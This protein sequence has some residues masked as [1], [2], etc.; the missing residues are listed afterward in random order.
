MEHHI[1]FGSNIT[2]TTS[3]CVPKCATGAFPL[4]GYTLWFGVWKH[5][6]NE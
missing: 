6:T 4:N 1:V 5:I 3:T 2:T